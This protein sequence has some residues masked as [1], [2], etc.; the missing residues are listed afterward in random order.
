[1][2]SKVEDGIKEIERGKFV[3]VVDDEDRENEG[4]LVIAAEKVTPSR[5]NYMIKNA[6]GIMCVPMT[7]ERLKE[8]QIPLMVENNTDKF[9][10]PFTV[11]VDAKRNTTTGVSVCDRLE[12]IKVLI[13]PES[14]PGDLVRPGHVFPLRA[15]VNGVIERAGH[16]EAAV[17]LCKLAGLYP[18]AVIAEIMNDDGSM[19]KLEQIEEFASKR[20][21]PIVTIKDLVEYLE[22]S[23]MGQ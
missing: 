13:N 4:D 22:K 9:N 21:I 23:Q 7:E 18:A 8:L 20:E 17:E 14:K 15:K 10:T 19:A 16:T 2:I 11:S 6:R 3:I 5:L 1:M 12:T